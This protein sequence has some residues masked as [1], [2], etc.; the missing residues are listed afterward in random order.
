MKNFFKV[1]QGSRQKLFSAPPK[2]KAADLAPVAARSNTDPTPS[3]RNLNEEQ[4]ALHNLSKSRSF[5]RREEDEKK[6]QLGQNHLYRKNTRTEWPDE[7]MAATAEEIRN[8]RNEILRMQIKGPFYPK[9]I[10]DMRTF[11]WEKK[12]FSPGGEPPVRTGHT[13]HIIGKDLVVCGGY[14]TGE[15]FHI[16][17]L[18]STE[19]V[20]TSFISSQIPYPFLSRV[21]HASALV[22]DSVYMFG[23]WNDE[24]RKYLAN[25]LLVRLEFEGSSLRVSQETCE[26]R[27]MPRARR[28]C[29]VVWAPNKLILFGG[30]NQDEFF[31]DIW[32]LSTLSGI[33]ESKIHRETSVWPQSKWKRMH[34]TGE[35]PRRRRGHGAAVV[36]LSSGRNRMYIFGGMYGRSRYFNDFFSLDLETLV[37]KEIQVAF[38][39]P[40]P[41]SE[42]AWHS[43]ESVR[44]QILVFGGTCGKN[45]FFN[46]LWVFDTCAERWFIVDTG[47]SP[48]PPP[49]ASHS[50]CIRPTEEG[51]ELIV[52]AGFGPEEFEEKT[53]LQLSFEDSLS[54]YNKA[55]A[56]S[57]QNPFSGNSQLLVSADNETEG[58]GFVFSDYSS[59]VFRKSS[60]NHKVEALSIRTS[61][62]PQLQA[63]GD[64]WVLRTV[65]KDEKCDNKIA[66]ENLGDGLTMNVNAKS[67]HEYRTHQAVLDIGCSKQPLRN[68]LE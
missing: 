50:L 43:M 11:K 51:F 17:H 38:G 34:A 60:D 49:R 42:R 33:P 25:G 35:R 62:A 23:G 53:S 26:D 31:N 63:M 2:L 1:F 45:H 32:T 4:D 5:E 58:R 48:A 16:L 20:E 30:W 6:E 66:K 8:A 40:E 21:G 29:T 27:T 13:A 68:I 56:H 59:E 18:N 52:Y 7:I 44:E 61:I 24:Q 36:T 28:D 9:Q 54:L 65:P 15:P 57:V 14:T 39:R 64:L 46:D 41:P 22:G 10:P 12:T 3:R 37:W 19:E 67:N 55:S 47:E